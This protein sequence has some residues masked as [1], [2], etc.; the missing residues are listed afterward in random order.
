MVLC[1]STHLQMESLSPSVGRGHSKLWYCVIYWREKITIWSAYT[2]FM[3]VSCSQHTGKYSIGSFMLWW[4]IEWLKLLSDMP[5]TSVEGGPATK[6]PSESTCYIHCRNTIKKGLLNVA[7]A[8]AVNLKWKCS[9]TS[10]ADGFSDCASSWVTENSN[11]MQKSQ[12]TYTSSH[13]PTI[14]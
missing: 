9:V 5:E 8:S 10:A 13:L 12:D 2:L 11:L 14:T 6:L 1:C 7:S 4:D 3:L